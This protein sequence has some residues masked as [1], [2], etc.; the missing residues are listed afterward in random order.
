MYVYSVAQR[1]NSRLDRLTV[2]VSASLSLS[3]SLSLSHTVRLLWTSDQLVA[4]A[5]TYKTNIADEYPCPQRDSN[6]RS[7]QSSGFRPTYALDHT[8]NQIGPLKMHIVN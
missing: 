7:Q 1:P 8:T 5:D 6:Q 4:E 2:Q 3:R